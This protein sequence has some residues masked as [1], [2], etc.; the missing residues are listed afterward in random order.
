MNL[1]F[2]DRIYLF[3]VSGKGF[4]QSGRRRGDPPRCWSCG[5][6]F[7]ER[8]D[9][10]AS[11]QQSHQISSASMWSPGAPS[12]GYCHKHALWWGQRYPQVIIGHW[13]LI[14]SKSYKWMTNIN[15]LEKCVQIHWGSP[16]VNALKA[17]KWAPSWRVYFS[18]E[19]GYSYHINDTFI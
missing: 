9:Q 14:V 15:L 6:Q 8:C 17:F 12:I 19:I 1:D 3:S 4:Q 18:F 11:L 2:Y 10:W 7:N 5:R 16:S 13:I